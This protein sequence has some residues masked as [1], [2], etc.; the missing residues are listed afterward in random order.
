LFRCGAFGCGAFGRR[1]SRFR[2]GPLAPD[3]QDLADVLHRRGIQ[4]LADPRE[5]GFPLLPVVTRHPHFDQLMALQAQVDLAQH[6][7][8]QPVVADRHDR[9]Q[10]VGSGFEYLALGGGEHDRG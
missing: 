10:V 8:G 9:V 4:R 6:R 1:F 5:T 3:H 7:V 2:G